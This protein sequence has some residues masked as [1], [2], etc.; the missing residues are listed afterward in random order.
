M[1]LA[2][3]LSLYVFLTTPFSENAA[4]C[5]IIGGSVS[6][7]WHSTYRMRLL[8]KHFPSKFMVFDQKIESRLSTADKSD[9]CLGISF[10]VIL[11]FRFF[12]ILTLF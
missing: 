9:I 5:R 11:L 3:H 2:L 4:D 7:I 6:R 8:T 10:W 12:L 1:G